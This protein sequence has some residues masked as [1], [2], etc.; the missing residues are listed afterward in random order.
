VVQLRQSFRA[1]PALTTLW[2][3]VSY[4]GA[5]TPAKYVGGVFGSTGSA[6]EDAEAGQSW[7][8]AGSGGIDAVRC[9]S[10]QE[11]L[12]SWKSRG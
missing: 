6:E 3:E 10:V 12:G 8:A 1:V 7:D 9:V 11:T 5:V 2:S 4:E